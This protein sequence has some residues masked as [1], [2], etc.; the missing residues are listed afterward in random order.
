MGIFDKAKEAL[1]THG[2]QADSL[3]D[4]AADLLDKKTGGQHGAQIDRGADLAKDRLGDYAGRERPA[5]PTDP[6]SPAPPA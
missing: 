4:K 3:V 1:S 5:D 6:V 2:D